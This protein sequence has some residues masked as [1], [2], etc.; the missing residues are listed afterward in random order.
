M[1]KRKHLVLLLFLILSIN[2]TNSSILFFKENLVIVDYPKS[3]NILENPPF[4]DNSPFNI[5]IPQN[6]AIDSSTDNYVNAITDSF[7]DMLVVAVGNWSVPVF[8][9]DSFTTL[10]DVTITDPEWGFIMEDIPIPDNAAPDP[11]EDGHLCI[12]DESTGVEYDFWQAKKQGNMWSASW[13]NNI[14][15]Y[16][17]GTYLWG[18]G[19][20]ASGFALTAGLILPYEFEQEIIDHAL[21]FSLD[22]TLVRQGGPILPATDSDGYSYDPLALPE[23]A[24]LQL[25][26][27]INLDNRNLTSS[28][29]IIAKALQE[30]GMILGD[31]GGGSPEIY[32]A[33]PIGETGGWED[34]LN[35]DSSGLVY[36]FE[37]KISITEFRV[38]KMGPQYPNPPSD[39][40]EDE[41]LPPYKIYTTSQESI[42]GYETPLFFIFS[43][44]GITIIIKKNV[45][46]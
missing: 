21:V 44:L 35:V 43:L 23:G 41:P 39:P 17:T 33:N 3:Q 24:R 15:I 38:L 31:I 40:W 36:L 8:Y 19:A 46:E 9:A 7:T 27:S 10:Y 37:D 20:R 1:I 12:I 25:D 5:K 14:S 34:F 11:E 42:P 16:S 6:A 45:I 29:K 4:S 18:A 32:A 2:F 13:G 30:Y 26:P 28:E 22:P